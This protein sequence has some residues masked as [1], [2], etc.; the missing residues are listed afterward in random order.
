MVAGTCKREATGIKHGIKH[1]KKH[2]LDHK[3]ILSGLI[4]CPI[5]GATMYRN[6]NR[7]KRAET[8]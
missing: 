1:A 4:K 8:S 3:H 2:S 6:V 5:C 7:K